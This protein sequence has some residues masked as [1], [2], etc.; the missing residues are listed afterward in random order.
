MLQHLNI[1]LVVR[2]PKLKA[3]FNVPGSLEV[4]G[5]EEMNMEHTENRQSKDALPGEMEE[6]KTIL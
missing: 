6:G 1:F 3:M 5:A 2:G 4:P